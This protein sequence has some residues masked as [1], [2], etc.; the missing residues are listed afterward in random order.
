MEWHKARL[1]VEGIWQLYFDI[2]SSVRDACD[3]PS[4]FCNDVEQGNF[5]NSKISQ[6]CKTK[7]ICFLF[8]GPMDEGQRVSTDILRYV[9]VECNMFAVNTKLKCNLNIRSIKTVYNFKHEY[10]KIQFGKKYLKTLNSNL[11]N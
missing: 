4:G 11:Y 2:C 5:G 6:N 3:I 9:L 1:G 7:K 8:R 10:R